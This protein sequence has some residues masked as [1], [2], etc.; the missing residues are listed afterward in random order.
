M[1]PNATILTQ[2][3]FV[4]FFSDVLSPS[5]MRVKEPEKYMLI[6]EGAWPSDECGRWAYIGVV[7]NRGGCVAEAQDGFAIL[8]KFTAVLRPST[9]Q[10][11][12][13]PMP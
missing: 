2:K 1:K 5:L 11:T 9:K 3:L 12:V 7:G 6:R 10:S 13:A 4:R 8:R